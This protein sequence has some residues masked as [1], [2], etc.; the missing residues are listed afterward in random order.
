MGTRPRTERRPTCLFLVEGERLPVF[1][2]NLFELALDGR[3]VCLGEVFPLGFDV[4]QRDQ[5]RGGRGGR[6]RRG[7]GRGETATRETVG[8]TGD[9]ESLH[10]VNEWVF[11][12][13]RI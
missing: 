6:R 1:F 9:A 5:G 4:A 13:E 10:G 11:G 2:L 8:G 7:R 3:L 12:Y